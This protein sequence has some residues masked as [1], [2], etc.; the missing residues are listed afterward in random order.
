[1]PVAALCNEWNIA[2]VTVHMQLMNNTLGIRAAAQT[3]AT[4]YFFI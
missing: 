4:Q 1:M 2:T 3:V